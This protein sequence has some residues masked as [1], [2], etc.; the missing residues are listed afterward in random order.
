MNGKAENKIRL[1]FENIDGFGVDET[2]SPLLKKDVIYFNN[3]FK[4][5][6]GEVNSGTE[7]R[8]H[9]NMVQQSH[10]LPKVL[11]FVMLHVAVVDTIDMINL[12][13]NNKVPNC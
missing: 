9:W 6:E 1:Y 10:F 3:L 4:R 12:Q 13:L 5:I 11:I 8:T 2:R 7:P